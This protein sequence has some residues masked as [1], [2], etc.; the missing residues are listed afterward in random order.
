M[1]ER[2]KAENIKNEEKILLKKKKFTK[3]S[4]S[5]KGGTAITENLDGDSLKY[6]KKKKIILDDFSNEDG[7]ESYGKESHAKESHAKEGH[8]KESYVAESYGHWKFGYCPN[9][10]ILRKSAHDN[11]FVNRKR[12]GGCSNTLYGCCYG[13]ATAAADKYGYNCFDCIKHEELYVWTGIKVG[14]ASTQFG[15]CRNSC[16]HAKK[17]LTDDCGN[18]DFKHITY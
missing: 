18:T 2:G 6:K 11:C 5:K 16:I 13:S 12:I 15:C 8:G 10:N 7:K 9:S 1:T 14:C 3:D 4:F 17:S